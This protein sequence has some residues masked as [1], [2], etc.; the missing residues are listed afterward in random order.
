[1]ASENEASCEGDPNF[2][3]ICGFFEKFGVAC[4]LNPVDFVE[5]QE[6]LENTHEVA[7]DLIELHIKL[8]RKARKSVSSERWERAI[9][10]ICHTYNS[11]DAWEI[12]RFGYKK[13][14]I[15]SKLRI[16]KHLLEMQFDLNVRFK[17]EINKMSATE[18]RT[19]PL[20]K[21]K[22]GHSYWFQTDES[23][24][25]RVYKE[26]P[27]EETWALVAKDRNGLVSLISQ[28]DSNEAA[29]SGSDSIMNEDSNSLEM[30]KPIL[31]TG[32]NDSNSDSSKQLSEKKS[33]CEE[34]E[35]LEEEQSIDNS[36]AVRNGNAVMD[37]DSNSALALKE[38]ADE[39]EEEDVEE[40]E[41]V[42]EEEEVEEEEVEEEE[43]EDEEDEEEEPVPAVPEV[44]MQE[45]PVL[46]ELKQVP[47]AIPEERPKTMGLRLKPLTELLTQPI[48]ESEK[49]LELSGIKNKYIRNDPFP[50]SNRK[51]VESAS[52]VDIYKNDHKRP[53]DYNSIEEPSFAKRPRTDR[54]TLL[55][56]KLHYQKQYMGEEEDDDDE[57]YD[58]YEDEEDE[59]GEEI[60]EPLM[61]IKGEGSGKDNKCGSEAE[62]P[63]VGDA[64][65]E[66]VMFV[67]G[68]GSGALCQTGNEKKSEDDSKSSKNTV[69]DPTEKTNTEQFNN[70]TKKEVFRSPP[71]KS[72]WESGDDKTETVGSTSVQKMVEKFED[73]SKGVEVP[74]K[75]TMPSFFFGPG[76]NT[77]SISALAK[78]NENDDIDSNEVSTE[79]ETKQI[80]ET[81]TVDEVEN[82]EESKNG[83]SKE[84]KS[85]EIDTKEI[86]QS[87]IQVDKENLEP[88]EALTKENVCNIEE[89][90]KSE[91]ED[92]LVK[93]T[94]NASIE[95]LEKENKS[96]TAVECKSIPADDLPKENKSESEDNL[97]KESENAPK[98]TL[99]E[100]RKS[101]SA[102]ECKSTP[103]DNLPKENKC[104]SE[105]NLVKES[106]N[107]PKE[108]L[109]EERK[110]ESAEEC[111]S[112]S[113]DNLPKENKG[114]SEDNLVKESE[115]VP[116]ETLEEERK[117]E[118][119]EECKSAPIDN[120]PKE[121]KSESA[122][123]LT[124]ESKSESTD[125]LAEECKS[126]SADNL[127]KESKSAPVDNQKEENKSEPAENPEEN[128]TANLKEDIKSES[129]ETIKVEIISESAKNIKEESKCELTKNLI[130]EGAC[131]LATNLKEKSISAT[132]ETI[133]VE[134]NSEPADIPK[135]EIK[136][137]SVENLKQELKIECP[138]TKEE[139]KSEI[140]ETINTDSKSESAET[141]ID[142]SRSESA[143]SKN[144]SPSNELLQK[145][146]IKD[147]D[148]K[149]NIIIE[150]V[151]SSSETTELANN[152]DSTFDDNKLPQ[153]ESDVMDC[154][155]E[156]EQP[157]D[158]A[159]TT[160][161]EVTKSSDTTECKG[162]V[163][164]TTK[165]ES[166][167]QTK[168]ESQVKIIDEKEVTFADDLSKKDDV[169]ISE[170]NIDGNSKTASEETEMKSLGPVPCDTSSQSVDSQEV[171]EKDSIESKREDPKSP[172]VDI[173]SEE[174]ADTPS[175]ECVD[176]KPSSSIDSK[177][178]ENTDSISEENKEPVESISIENIDSKSAE[179]VESLN[180]ESVDTRSPEIVEIIAETG[181]V[182]PIDLRSDKSESS[183]TSIEA[184][185]SPKTKP[186]TSPV[187]IEHNESALADTLQA[188]N[189]NAIEDN[190]NMS[191]PD[192]TVQI[193]DLVNKSETPTLNLKD[194]KDISH[195]E[196]DV[197][198]EKPEEVV[199]QSEIVEKLE[200][201]TKEL[202]EEARVTEVVDEKTEN[203]DNGTCSIEIVADKHNEIKGADLKVEENVGS[204]TA[205]DVLEKQSKNIPEK[206]DT[207]E[208]VK[209][210]RA[211]EKS[212]ISESLESSE[213]ID[214]I[215]ITDKPVAV[216]PIAVVDVAVCNLKT[217]DL[218]ADV[219]RN[220]VLP[221]EVTDKNDETVIDLKVRKVLEVQPATTSAIVENVEI[222]EK[223][224]TLSDISNDDKSEI[225]EA[226][227]K[228]NDASVAEESKEI[229]EESETVVPKVQIVSENILPDKCQTNNNEVGENKS[230]KVSDPKSETSFVAKISATQSVVVTD[231]I[232]NKKILSEPK[233]NASDV[234]ATKTNPVD[235]KEDDVIR[236]STST[237]VKSEKK[238]ESAEV[239]S[240][241]KSKETHV[242]EKTSV[243]VGES[244]KKE[245]KSAV[246]SDLKVDVKIV[247]VDK[248]KD[249]VG[250]ATEQT[251]SKP[252][253]A[254]PN[255]TAKS[256]KKSFKINSILSSK[257]K[258]PEAKS[259]DG[260][261]RRVTGEE[262]GKVPDI[263]SVDVSSD[264]KSGE[265]LPE[266]KCDKE[267]DDVGLVTRSLKAAPKDVPE[268]EK[269]TQEQEGTTPAKG[270][271]KKTELYGAPVPSPKRSARL[272]N[273]S[274]KDTVPEVVVVNKKAKNNAVDDKPSEECKKPK[275]ETP[276]PAESRRLRL[277][278]RGN[279]D[280]TSSLDVANI[281]KQ[282]VKD[283]KESPVA[284]KNFD[285]LK[286]IQEGEKKMTV[287][288][289]VCLKKTV[290][291][292]TEE[293]P[294]S[295]IS[296]VSDGDCGDM[297]NVSSEYESEKEEE[298][299][300][301]QEE[302]LK[303]AETKKE[304]VPKKEVESKPEEVVKKDEGVKKEEKEDEPKKDEKIPSLAT[305]SFDYTGSPP[306]AKEKINVR[307]TRKRGRVSPP[308]EKQQAV[309]GGKRRKMRGKRT[310]DTELRKSIEDQK[311][312]EIS[313]SEEEKD[314]ASK[315]Q[316]K[317]EEVKESTKKG[318][319]KKRTLL[320]LDIP[321]TMEVVQTG[322]R[323]S[324]RIAQIKIKEE[325]E[326]RKIE[327]LTMHDIKEKHKKSSRKEDDKDYKAEKRKRNKTAVTEDETT[328]D[329]ESDEK[330]KKKQKRKHKNPKFDEHNPW[331]SSSDSSSQ[332]SHVEEEEEEY[333]EEDRDAPLKSDHEFSPESDLENGDEVQP[334]KRARTVRKEDAPED[335]VVEVDDTSCEKC[336]K[337][338]HPEWILLCD[339]CDSGWHCSCLR[340]ALLVIPEGDWY[341]PPC[342]HTT[343]VI[344]LQNRLIEFD[345]QVS[346]RQAEVRRKERLA[347]VGISLDNVLPTKEHDE[348]IKS[349][350]KQQRRDTRDS[351][352]ESASDSSS[353][354]GSGSGSTAS[355]S[356]DEPI[357]QLRQRRQAHSYRFND[358]DEL[359][360]SAIQDE[361]QSAVVVQSTEIRG[362]DMQTIVNAEAAAAA[363]ETQA[364]PEP[365][366]PVIPINA[367]LP[368]NL[369]HTADEAASDDEVIK[370]V[371]KLIGKKKHRKLNSL[372]ISSDDDD[373]GSDEDFKGSSSDEDEEDEFDE[374]LDSDSS[375][376]GRRKRK[377]G[378]V[379][380]S[381][382]ARISRYDRD[383]INDDS[384]EDYAAPRRKKTRSIWDESES[385]E[386]DRSW[387]R[388]KKKSTPRKAPSTPRPRKPK[389][390]KKKKNDDD[391]D[392][393]V[394]SKKKP[395]IKYGGLDSEEDTGRR[396][397]GKK[398]T[399]VDALGSDSDDDL[400]RKNAV[401]DD[402]SE[403]EFVL[404]EEEDL[405]DEAVG[406]SDD[407]NDDPLI[408]GA[409]KSGSKKG[410][411]KGGIK[412]IKRAQG[413]EEEALFPP[414]PDDFTKTTE[415]VPPVIAGASVEKEEPNPIEQINKNIEAMDEKEMEMMM[416]EEEYANKQLQ[417]VAEQL[418]KEKRRKEL[419]V[420]KKLEEM[421]TVVPQNFD[422]PPMVVDT[423]PVLEPQTQLHPIMMMEEKTP[424]K[425]GRKPKSLSGSAEMLHL[426]P[427]SGV[428]TT[429]QSDDMS[430]L[431]GSNLNPDGTPKKRRGRGK[432][433]KTLEKEAAAAAAAAAR[434]SNAPSEAGDS[435]EPSLSET[436]DSSNDPALIGGKLG[437]ASAPQPF[438]Q[439]QPVPSVITRMLQTQPGKPA[440]PV[441]PPINYEMYG[442]DN[443]PEGPSPPIPSPSPQGGPPFLTSP[444]GP[445][446]GVLPPGYRPTLNHYP[447]IRSGAPPPMRHRSPVP[448]NIPSGMFLSH[449]PLD[450]SP[451]G[452]STI[453]TVSS[454]HGSPAPS[455]SPLSNKSDPTPP[456]PTY[457]RPPMVRFPAATQGPMA[458]HPLPTMMAQH[459]LRPNVPFAHFP[460]G[461]YQQAA[462][463]SGEDGPHFSNPNYSEFPPD[464]EGPKNY[465]EENGEFGGL[466][467]YFSSQREDDLDT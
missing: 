106:E 241:E 323:Q 344:N 195:D 45:K 283:V 28:L 183:E 310:V 77:P 58:E 275:L 342:L 424:K 144:D 264:K 406:D 238:T 148:P 418:E 237:D 159:T 115:I 64:I 155:S 303:P 331:K 146:N 301:K 189:S 91:S 399:Y 19:Q 100:E 171:P 366:P 347:Y 135:E 273:A 170:P 125:N 449:H 223:L 29:K 48:I 222:S 354:S 324:R 53:M 82:I 453:T 427:G 458:R 377:G 307:V 191:E 55:N 130:V 337:S 11:Q 375:E 175:T 256:A 187:K 239:K 454:E 208:E 268:P 110:S 415:V 14:R 21:D 298:Q 200:D 3:V 316:K 345:K 364:A 128:N 122:D 74:P 390:K 50:M 39:E 437:V 260:E 30:E 119:A 394:Y 180:S 220:N 131:E 51:A 56:N 436:G 132:T 425:R 361:V 160:A 217:S 202:A 188:S 233:L 332:E 348:N 318:H 33:S 321:D 396:T 15:G 80:D 41:E 10:N 60:E 247:N 401:K 350:P 92:N 246:V 97:V 447:V 108:T 198:E 291:D 346:K 134:S 174:I 270:E 328:N 464:G 412:R 86:V 281:N 465:D 96:E 36:T 315:K 300:V 216:N 398:I 269:Q 151:S 319:K 12:E 312:K 322:V 63:I 284:K 404:N 445:P 150:D 423:M 109:E 410:K 397:R 218:M 227:D 34:E 162:D 103:A 179:N 185:K 302:E 44:K 81:E 111:K 181:P 173:N 295:P 59:V 409:I 462:A 440:Y 290:A 277:R 306:P 49:K 165:S 113:V 252:A 380:R 288:E 37:T 352:S 98:E 118:S 68:V 184:T 22:T 62:S 156:V 25:I 226:E 193:N 385:E 341:C 76:F 127:A 31:D 358:Y 201:Q 417:M 221:T 117:S 27:D 363:A 463:S 374:D 459:M 355:E 169:S 336:G 212:E 32:Q 129:S 142:E 262:P 95:T 457:V 441:G 121:S 381:T 5:L 325:A 419:E 199:E 26:D 242:P 230:Q 245:L 279:R 294:N 24:T 206:P 439:S 104:E 182:E 126:E 386:S 285:N 138:E 147:D 163:D 65:E 78:T 274:V 320:G 7:T 83:A 339:G 209:S 349:K 196:M 434:A 433:K 211:V 46:V 367:D 253:I 382:R 271:L 190:S 215:Q 402:D 438:S 393:E 359:I 176:S 266:D 67:Y 194:D 327:E 240:I 258:E 280:S 259:K 168:N 292:L 391:S 186:E 136:R 124:E 313:S 38:V 287:E 392:A 383:F 379:R 229:I 426:M 18:L 219:E 387:G 254:A 351:A 145:T 140:L 442:G 370:P 177:Q 330:K 430:D 89:K 141:L 6:M 225:I 69:N 267:V 305:L 101:E 243:Q 167:Q 460:Y 335:D 47:A 249:E 210:E 99:E 444:G 4:G 139:F 214:S 326:R 13:A 236:E 251:E 407:S 467:S 353:S 296:F 213:M 116:K 435:N 420:A 73:L 232:Q 137:E 455:A 373:Q 133:N 207:I 157:V 112:T 293:M 90:S 2:A 413:E 395:K 338:D 450:P 311:K 8:L 192:I 329:A 231:E 17:N 42:D 123:N 356:E 154:S 461:A 234:T 54:P 85:N 197:V 388:R 149:V 429:P 57:D 432:G 362:K 421:P 333:E 16:L 102:E 43:E 416:E 172:E 340:P 70:L 365:L 289:P 317:S 299:S 153:K 408:V 414:L 94:E 466:V 360:N 105:D 376:F 93:E 286:S 276:P 389:S 448:Q 248:S 357:Y 114:K 431:S 343:L 261:K 378:P 308:T 20:G 372:D 250:A 161:E 9:V 443:R 405:R 158:D 428:P 228:E 224:E 61:L 87:I 152:V 369:V 120:L 72:K 403:D 164:E 88:A 107:V 204:T 384:D 263:K 23:C 451:S 52:Y 205:M 40:E 400:R 244:S 456:P 203:V 84:C 422:L 304:V 265:I 75:K 79:T 368:S 309:T 66:P 143:E 452:G 282:I 411:G 272:R 255:N 257:E 178:I 166:V 314:H 371:K 1:M 235:A 446:R 278:N 71:K 334:L 297:G 35:E